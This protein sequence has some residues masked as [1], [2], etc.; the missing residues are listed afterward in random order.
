MVVLI[1]PPFD[2]HLGLLQSIEDLSIQ[3]L[4]SQSTVE[5][6]NVSVFP[7]TARLNEESFHADL[8]E[9]LPNGFSCELRSVVG[10]N[11]VWDTTFT[12]KKIERIQ[13]V[14]TVQPASDFD[15]K[16]LSSELIHDGQQPKGATLPE[17]DRKRNR[18]S[19]RGPSLED[20][21]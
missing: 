15:C 14:L 21:V 16:T 20:A 12:E 11:V 2:E 18:S 17:F 13:D 19:R 10:A 9:P 5:R 3:E 6:F 4:V 8:F 7:R 1:A